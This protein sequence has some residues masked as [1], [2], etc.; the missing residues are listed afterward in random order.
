MPKEY[1]ILVTSGDEKDSTL[2]KVLTSRIIELKKLQE[3]RMQVVEIAQIQQWNKTLWS[4]QKNPENNLVLVI[5]L[6]GF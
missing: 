3:V 4:Q 2:V 1:I 5:M 6:C